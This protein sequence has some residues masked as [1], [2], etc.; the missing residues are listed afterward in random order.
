MAVGVIAPVAAIGVPVDGAI[1][2]DLIWV[3]RVEILGA[4]V[5]RQVQYTDHKTKTEQPKPP[6]PSIPL[7]SVILPQ[8]RYHV[9]DGSLPTGLAA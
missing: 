1:R 4:Q 7:H 9:G 2:I 3:L 6:E 5:W 8:F